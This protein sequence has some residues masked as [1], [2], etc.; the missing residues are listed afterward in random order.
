MLKENGNKLPNLGSRSATSAPTTPSRVRIVGMQ[1]I[2]PVGHQVPSPVSNV[3]AA[4]QKSAALELP[5]ELPMEGSPVKAPLQPSRAKTAHDL[6]E[7]MQRMLPPQAAGIPLRSQQ[8]GRLMSRQPEEQ[9]EQ[10]K[11]VEE[12]EKTEKDDAKEE[13]AP[14]PRTVVG[15]LSR[16]LVPQQAYS[17]ELGELPCA[18]GHKCTPSDCCLHPYRN[19]VPGAQS[20]PKER[21]MVASEPYVIQITDILLV[22]SPRSLPDQPI[23]G[24]HLVRSDGTITLGLYGTVKVAGM[25]IDEAREEI[26]RHLSSFIRDPKVNVDVYAYNSQKYYIIMD[27][28]GFGEQVVPVPFTGRETVLDA[29]SLVNGLPSVASKKRI[30]I[31]RP[32][33]GDQ[34]C[35]QI[36][37]V[38]WTGIAQCGRWDTNYQLFPNDRLYIQSDR[39]LALDGALSKI[40][41]PIERLFGVTLL[42]ATTI[43]KLQNMGRFISNTTTTTPVGP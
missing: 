16:T 11:K 38:D 18:F 14:Q 34:K 36:L 1:A 22:E 9:L 15:D 24:E 32:M 28:A 4:S 41:S 37:P 43:S 21:K 7:G 23:A 31:A 33:P 25:T 13:T 27:G 30:W 42:G 10:P 12:L 19:E 6:P 8:A 26:E 29:V 2:Q 39:L 3:S 17:S 20:V 5:I 40:I 35:G